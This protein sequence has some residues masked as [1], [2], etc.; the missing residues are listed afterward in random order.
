MRC[1]ITINMVWRKNTVAACHR[2]HWSPGL[3]L[4]SFSPAGT[5]P[6][7]TEEQMMNSPWHTQI[8]FLIHVS[9]PL[10]I[11]QS[12]PQNILPIAWKNYVPYKNSRAF[13]QKVEPPP[14]NPRNF[15][16]AWGDWN[17]EVHFLNRRLWCW[18]ISQVFRYIA[19]TIRISY[20][21]GD[22]GTKSS[23]L[24]G[25]FLYSSQVRL[26]LENNQIK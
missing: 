25:R 7:H 18:W 8:K 21:P 22:T 15:L 26:L 13:N 12:L 19:S 3:A 2:A 6:L 1:A 4:Q 24:K 11:L 5:E 20:F 14:W 23:I 9:T 16:W 17:M 10:L